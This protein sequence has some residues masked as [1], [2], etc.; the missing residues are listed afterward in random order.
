M[1]LASLLGLGSISRANTYTWHAQAGDS[2]DVAVD[3]SPFDGGDSAG[4]EAPTLVALPGRTLQLTTERLK[5]L[6]ASEYVDLVKVSRLTIVA[7]CVGA[8]PALGP[9]IALSKCTF[10]S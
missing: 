10:S 4:A 1:A 3:S 9:L 8:A 5:R 6:S 7:A 2:S